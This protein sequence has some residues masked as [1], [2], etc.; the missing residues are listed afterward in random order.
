MQHSTQKRGFMLT[1][2]IGQACR[3]QQ[4]LWSCHVQ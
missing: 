4:R 1:D 3:W 2:F